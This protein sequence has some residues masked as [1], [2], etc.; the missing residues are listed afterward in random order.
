MTL[1]HI[2]DEDSIAPRR[3]KFILIWNEYHDREETSSERELAL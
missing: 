2:A 1:R 3:A